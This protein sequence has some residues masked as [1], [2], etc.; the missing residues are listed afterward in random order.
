MEGENDWSQFNRIAL[1]PEVWIP[2]L[3]RSHSF[4]DPFFSP[5]PPLSDPDPPP[6]L[7]ES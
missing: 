3:L 2:G 6:T 1:G 7:S 4:Q 5:F